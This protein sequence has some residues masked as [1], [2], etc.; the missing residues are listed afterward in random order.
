MFKRFIVEFEF[1]LLECVVKVVVLVVEIEEE[2]V[3]DDELVFLGVG[4]N[5]ILDEVIVVKVLVVKVFE[6]EDKLVS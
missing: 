3:L 1:F 4:D 5:G 6:E 2:M